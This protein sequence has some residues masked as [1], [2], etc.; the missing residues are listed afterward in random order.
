M[1]RGLGP[2]PGAHLHSAACVVP[3]ASAARLLLGGVLRVACCVS[4]KRPT[5]GNEAQKR[6]HNA[7]HNEAPIKGPNDEIAMLPL[8]E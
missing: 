6:P 2:S 8:V 3:A 4:L 7:R 5:T 1:Q